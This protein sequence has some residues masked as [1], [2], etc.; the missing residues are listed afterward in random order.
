MPPVA[1]QL[2]AFFGLPGG[3]EWIV[4]AIVGLLV[5]GRRLPEVGR[6]IGR[7]LAQ[8]R[9]GLSDIQNEVTHAG[10]DEPPPP[11]LD[12]DPPPDHPETKP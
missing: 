12:A 1:S 10:A 9:R 6:N 7:S 11:Q 4:I 2:G 5:F 8:F 3:S